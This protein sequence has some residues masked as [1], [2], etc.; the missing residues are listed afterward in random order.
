MAAEAAESTS[1]SYGEAGEVSGIMPTLLSLLLV[2]GW[3]RCRHRSGK[4]SSPGDVSSSVV[5]LKLDTLR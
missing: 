3:R 2:C 4:C 1:T 5:A